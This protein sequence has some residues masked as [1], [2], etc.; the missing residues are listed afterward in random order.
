[1]IWKKHKNNFEK[2]PPEY[3]KFNSLSETINEFSFKAKC[4]V[5]IIVRIENKKKTRQ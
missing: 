4:L 1:M 3:T 5:L 2:R